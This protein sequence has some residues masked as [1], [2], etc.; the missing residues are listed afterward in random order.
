MYL[1]SA[2][3]EHRLCVQLQYFYS[4]REMRLTLRVKIVDSFRR[5]YRLSSSVEIAE[6]FLLSQFI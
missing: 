3:L 2:V 6:F 1:S 4:R 5:Y